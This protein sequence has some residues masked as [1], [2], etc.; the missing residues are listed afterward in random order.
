METVT[1]GDVSKLSKIGKA[2]SYN[3]ANTRLTLV[4]CVM[5]CC[6]IFIVP[7]DS[8]LFSFIPLNYSY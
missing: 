5:L 3:L 4:L 7:V 6:W 1:E 2:L 8:H